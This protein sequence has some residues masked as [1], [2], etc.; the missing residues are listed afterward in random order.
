MRMI[1]V[2]LLALTCA[3]GFAQP[4][5][6]AAESARTSLRTATTTQRTFASRRPL[7][8]RD[9]PTSGPAAAYRQF[10]MEELKNVPLLESKIRDLMQMQQERTNLSRQRSQLADPS[11]DKPSEEQLRE[12][13]RLLRRED[14][15]TSRQEGLLHDFIRDSGQIQ[16]QIAARREEI[17]SKLD[18]KPEVGGD[19]DTRNLWRARRMYDFLAQRLERLE[20]EPD[21]AE[22]LRSLLRGIWNTDEV[23]PQMAEQARKRLNQIQQ[24]QEELRR[25]MNQID[26]QVE[27]LQELLDRAGQR[28][29][30]GHLRDARQ[31]ATTKEQPGAR[32][33]PPPD[34]RDLDF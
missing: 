10:L 2:T 22:V 6:Q 12:F 19:L 33:Q 32:R 18:G 23:D 30:T 21:R 16:A 9:F 26:D 13:H 5:E 27:Q 25:R 15:L 31:P 34:K 3:C 28:R 14:D 29:G 1:A 4:R 24:D 11:G 17:R 7:F 20:E 8:G